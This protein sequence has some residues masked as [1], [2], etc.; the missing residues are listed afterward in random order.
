MKERILKDDPNTGKV[1]FNVGKM[2]TKM[3][4]NLIFVP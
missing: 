4:Q 2:Y 1:T 3:G